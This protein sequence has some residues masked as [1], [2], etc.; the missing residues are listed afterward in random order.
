MP[1]VNIPIETLIADLRG[2]DWQ[3]RCDAA[4]MLGQSGDPRAVDA[5]LPDLQDPDWRVRRN[6]VQALGALKSTRAINGIL[7]AL[8]DRTATVRERAAVAL[9]RIKDPQTIP[10]LI[11]VL[12]ED[13][14]TF[15]HLNK[16]AYQAIRKFGRK[17]GPHLMEA[18][19]KNPNVFLVELLAD[20]KVEGPAD[21]F[22][23]LVASPDQDMRRTALSSLGKSRD[24]RAVEFLMNVLAEGDLE[25]Q[26]LAVQGLGKVHTT[27]AIPAMLSLLQDD[28]L[29]GL[30]SG[31]YHAISEAF[32]E[33]AGI[34]N[35][36][37]NAYPAKFPL[38]F[39]FSGAST[40]LPEMMGL[41]GNEGFRKLN[42]IL[43][44]AEKRASELSGT[45]NLP[46]ELFQ[47]MAD[48]TWKWGAMFADAREAGTER[49][50]KLIELLRAEQPL[51]RAAS[52]LTLVWYTASEALSPLE[53]ASHDSD[54]T[55]QRAATWAH[56]AL[57][58]F[59]ESQGYSRNYD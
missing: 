13:K 58:K 24:P 31:L 29:Y 19:R 33:F 11:E 51:K 14:R 22:I 26:T 4:R 37:N 54:A 39:N 30:R 45:S 18:L 48:Q 10:A 38:A 27:Q 34:K 2:T 52:A 23:K 53:Q 44:D 12:V 32:Q 16:G 59:L 20:S 35:D 6:A 9:G 40:G 1:K 3:K 43:G 25:S 55:V 46:P 8:T 47:A 50:N 7:S 42:Q 21:L 5:L 41:M 28:Q 36:V 15:L 56:V 57:K 17:A 49:V